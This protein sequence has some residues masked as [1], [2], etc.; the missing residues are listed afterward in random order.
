MVASALFGFLKYSELSGRGS[1]R[2]EKDSHFSHALTVLVF[3]S[4][5][6]APGYQPH[7]VPTPVPAPTTPSTPAPTPVSPAQF[8][9]SALSI[10][11]TQIVAGEEAT[12]KA[13]VSNIGEAEDTEL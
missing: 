7:P 3:L 2:D 10:T 6:L 8:K 11:P 4:L 5:A 13:D 9:V 1:V 12:I